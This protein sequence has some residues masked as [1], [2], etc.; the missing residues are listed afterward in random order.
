MPSHP[1]ALLTILITIKLYVTTSS[2][3]NWTDNK[4]MDESG[5]EYF[6]QIFIQVSKKY[7]FKESVII[8]TN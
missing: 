3:G 6:E 1:F 2:I 5:K 8:K 7:F 4:Q